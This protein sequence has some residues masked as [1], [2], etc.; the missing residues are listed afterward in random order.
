MA[1]TVECSQ[2]ASDARLHRSSQAMSVVGNRAVVFGGELVPRQ[3]VDNKIDVINLG[4]D[5]GKSSCTFPTSF[6]INTIQ[7]VLSAPSRPLTRH[8]PPALAV[9]APSSMGASGSSPAEGAWK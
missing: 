4:D 7:P 5:S 2:V 8:L 9:Q 6:V 1:I 3:P